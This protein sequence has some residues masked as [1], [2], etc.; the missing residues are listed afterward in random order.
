MRPSLITKKKFTQ[1]AAEQNA[2]LTLFIAYPIKSRTRSYAERAI[3]R[4]IYTTI[5]T[6]TMRF[7]DWRLVGLQPVARVAF[8]SA[9]VLYVTVTR[10]S[11]PDASRGATH[12]PSMSKPPSLLSRATSNPRLLL[13]SART[14]VQDRLHTSP[15][16]YVA[17]RFQFFR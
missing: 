16:R 5:H 8:L 12:H 15:S 9:R 1:D 11:I 4:S 3:R 17:S 7:A 10:R 13:V 6:R 14:L 2:A